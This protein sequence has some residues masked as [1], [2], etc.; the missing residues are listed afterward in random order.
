[1]RVMR[2]LIEFIV[3]LKGRLSIRRQARS[4]APASLLRSGVQRA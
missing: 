2:G 4:L 1:M 3:S